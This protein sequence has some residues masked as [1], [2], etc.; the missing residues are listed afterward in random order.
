MSFWRRGTRSRAWWLVAVLG[1]SLLAVDIVGQIDQ[2]VAT[3]KSALF[4]VA[5]TVATLAG[6]WVWAWRPQTHMGPL[7]L[8]WPALSVA[9]DLI[10]PFP[11]SRLV[12]TVGLALY[13]MGAIVFAQM[14]LSYPNG[15]LQGRL[16]W[17]YI[18]V[19][20]YAAQVIQNL[21]N[22]LFYDGRGCPFCFPREQSYLFV[23]STSFPLGWWN[24]GWAIE[25]IAILPIGLALVYRKFLRA[26]RGAGRTFG[27]LVLSLT[28][29][30]IASWIVLFLVA[31]DDQ[32]ALASVSSLSWVLHSASLAG[33]LSVFLGLALTRRARGVVGDLVVE[34]GR[35]KPGGVRRALARAIG[36][37]SLELALWLPERR[38]WVD[39]EGHDVALLES[40]DRAVTFI[41]KDLAAIVH[42]P[43]FLD[44][45][46]MLEAAG[47]AAR[48]ALENER[49]QAAFRAQLAELRES[50]ARIVRAGDEERR[51][52]ERDLHDG[53]QQRLL[54][55]GMAVQLLRSAGGK[56]QIESLL[57]ET[58]AEVQSALH[59]LRELARGIHP[60]VL[61]D[62]GLAAA[63]RTLAERSAIPIEVDACDERFPGEVETAV[64]FIVAEALANVAKHALASRASVKV[65]RLNG[66]VAVEVSDDG[67][68]GATVEGGGT[69]LRGLADRAG[70]LD[71]RLR[72]DS[73]RGGGTRL[74]VEIP[75]AS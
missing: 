75:C 40:P 67:V 19:L 68:G 9:G 20:A 17:I 12:T 31:L 51:R 32:E 29:G 49:L 47:S 45:P 27:P 64:Y 62:H 3:G 54:G 39:E 66:T 1:I 30:T 63:V 8:W 58:E 13:T 73:P 60:A 52:L 72:L 41:G 14:T 35:A 36:D 42:H 23:G 15:K 55:I 38:A 10:V 74:L 33:A 28:I 50:R 24:R 48:L 6:L 34:L 25:I 37:P 18:F 22:L 65:E 70:A 61:T 7:I 71:G 5:M 53:A 21:G 2:G 69:G 59:E 11:D 44:Q 43:V 26:G 4:F 57:N 16:A 56:E 46:A